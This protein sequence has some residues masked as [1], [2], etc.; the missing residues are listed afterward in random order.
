[1]EEPPP[2]ELA[3]ETVA[4][5]WAEIAPLIDAAMDRI[6]TPGEFPVHPNSEL[7]ADDAVSNPFHVSHTARWCINSGV[8]HLQHSS[9]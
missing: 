2:V 5:K 3:D 1:V 9:R 8:E 6:Q 4:A 7:A